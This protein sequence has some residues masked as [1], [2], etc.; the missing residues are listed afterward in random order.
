MKNII[1]ATFLV[2]GILSAGADTNNSLP[3]N[4]QPQVQPSSSEMNASEIALLKQEVQLQKNFQDNLL[5]VVVYS[6]G[7]VGAIA[8]LLVGYNWWSAN[9]IYERDKSALKEEILNTQKQAQLA[10]E[11]KMTASVIRSLK[12]LNCG[13]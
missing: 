13:N 9:K 10:F 1:V 3:A 2:L 6:L 11:G 4:P 7:T 5:K 12:T 8:L